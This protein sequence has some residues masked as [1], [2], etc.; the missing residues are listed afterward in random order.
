LGSPLST[1]GSCVTSSGAR[2][3]SSKSRFWVADAE[4]SCQ[5][6]VILLA[7]LHLS[8]IFSKTWPSLLLTLHNCCHFASSPP[9]YEL[10]Q[11]YY[12][13]IL[14][15]AIEKSVSIRYIPTAC[16]MLF[17]VYIQID[18]ENKRYLC[19][20]KAGLFGDILS[21]FYTNLFHNRTILE[22]SL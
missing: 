3:C 21:T 1:A 9:Y 17:R 13:Y 19:K 8:S 10:L 6:Y 5:I 15:V 12:N 2:A 11:T 4:A 18:R 22:T 14:V 7:R 16:R 20:A